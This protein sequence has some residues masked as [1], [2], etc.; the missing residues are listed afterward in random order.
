MF[1]V[2]TDKEAKK[3]K[4]QSKK[5]GFRNGAKRMEEDCEK[6]SMARIMG[7]IIQTQVLGY[8]DQNIM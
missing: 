7:H 6:K 2:Q 1:L 8:S 3:E 5:L 4:N